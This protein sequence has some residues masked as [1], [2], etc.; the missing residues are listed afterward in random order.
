MNVCGLV[1]AISGT[2]GKK[3]V[4]DLWTFCVIKFSILRLSRAKAFHRNS[5]NSFSFEVAKSIVVT[6]DKLEISQV[7][8][9]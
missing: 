7:Y 2:E 5:E 4:I 1:S 8:Q 3:K 6:H 9:R